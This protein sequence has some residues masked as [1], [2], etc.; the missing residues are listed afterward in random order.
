LDFVAHFIDAAGVDVSV[1]TQPPL[2]H[3]E[4]LRRRQSVRQSVRQV[5]ST[6]RNVQPSAAGANAGAV[7]AGERRW[8]GGGSMLE[9]PRG[10]IR[11]S[12]RWPGEIDTRSGWSPARRSRRRLAEKAA[13]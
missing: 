13:R 12:G 10:P 6:R 5:E 4:P 11:Y 1:K 7:V 2:G 3:S 8:V 9:F